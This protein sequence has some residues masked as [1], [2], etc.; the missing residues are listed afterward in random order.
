MTPE[1]ILRD[2]L[3]DAAV[4]IG[5]PDDFQPQLERPRDPSFGDW[6]SNAAMLLARHLKRKP[7]EIAQD[8]V[9]RLDVAKAGVSEAYVAGAGFINF[10]LAAGAE[11][12]AL[13]GL[14]AAGSTYGRSDEGGRRVVN[15]EFVSANPT[16]PLHV[17]HGRQAA[18]G[19]AI[20]TLLEWTGWAVTREFYYND[21]G[22]QIANLGRS[23]QARVREVTTGVGDIPEGGYHGEYIR[24]IAREYVAQH[25][26]DAQ[27]DDL[28]AIRAFAVAYLRGEQDK[29]LQAFGVKFDVYYLESSLYSDGKVDETVQMLTAAGQTFEKDGALWLRTTDYGD[30][31]DRVMR[32]SDGSYT[33]FLP[34]VAY[35]LAKWRRGFSRAIDV[36]GADHHSTVTR[37][38]AGL[39][40]LGMGIPAGY[41]EYELHQMVTVMKGGEEVKIS[42]RAGSYVT[43]RD[44]IDEV[45]RDAVRYF[46]LMR[47]SDSQLVFDVDVAR[48]QSEEN[49]VYYIQMAHARVCGIF[50]VGEVD[51]TTITGAGVDWSALAEDDERELVKALLGFPAL[52]TAA[53]R[54]LAPH[55]V[56]S[57]LLETARLVHTWYHKH[58]VLGEPEPIRSARLALARAAQVTLANGLAMLGITAPERM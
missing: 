13:V 53:A 31:K 27:G 4:A 58:H 11:A 14:L 3:R 19:D 8:L 37:V 22:V 25:P 52:V 41:P 47:K 35:H 43:V 56:A 50:R 16:G 33:Y 9:A 42:K 18:L 48:A 24:E 12:Q 5:A 32:K 30:D 10:R 2:A 51:A 38:R 34:D 7:L 36:Q 20:S 57:Y 29:D 39:Q 46:L 17:G 40:A 49:P 1:T 15:V 45:G 6:A 23:V 54:T 21:A 55:L 44:L 26:Q 28:E